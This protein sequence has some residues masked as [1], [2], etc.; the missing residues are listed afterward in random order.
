[1]LPKKI[2]NSQLILIWFFGLIPYLLIEFWPFNPVFTY[3]GNEKVGK[4]VS[5]CSMKFFTAFPFWWVIQ[6]FERRR[7]AENTARMQRK[8]LDRVTKCYN[9][10]VETVR[11]QTPFHIRPL[12]SHI[13]LTAWGKVE[14]YVRTA[15]ENEPTHF[16]KL[17]MDMAVVFTQQVRSDKT[18]LE[19]Y[20]ANFSNAFTEQ[21]EWLARDTEL[22]LARAQTFGDRYLDSYVSVVAHLGD[23]I[24]KLEN[25]YRSEHGLPT[26]DEPKVDALR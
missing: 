13:E 5:D 11:D 26:L 18:K 22:A 10:F 3:A 7:K 9:E 25:I 4:L 2:S 15:V 6:W 1:M 23:N 24:R 8:F 14:E 17:V 19:P 16:P 21:A 12:T 20:L